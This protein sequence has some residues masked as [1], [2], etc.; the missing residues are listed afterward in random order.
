MRSVSKNTIIL[1]SSYSEAFYMGNIDGSINLPF[2]QILNKD[3]TF[4]SE[5]EINQLIFEITGLDQFD[6][7]TQ[8]I[9]SCRAGMTACILEL[10]H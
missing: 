10:G 6:K 7:E 5:K 1:D 8:I 2:A 4:K 3:K 9:L